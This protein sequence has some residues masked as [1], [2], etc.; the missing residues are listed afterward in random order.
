MKTGLFFDLRN[1]PEWRRPWPAVYADA[2]GLMADLDAYVDAIWLS[3]HHD[4]P[5][6][7]LPQ[8]L[9]MAAAVAARTSHARIGTAVLLGA[10]RHPR[11][12]AEQAAVVDLV[13]DGRTELGIGAGSGLREF[14][15]FGV[16]ARER[17]RL[18]NA[19]A[20]AV[21]DLLWQPRT[22]PPPVQRRLPLWLGYQG[23]KRAAQAGDIG[24][25]LLSFSR[26]AAEPYL[27]AHA[28]AGHDPG[29]ARM[30]GVVNV[31]VANDP[32]RAWR[33]I[34]HNAAYQADTYR[35]ATALQPESLSPVDPEKL[36]TSRGGA[37]PFLQTLTVDDTVRYVTELTKDLPVEHVYFWASIAGM[38]PD[39]AAE[40]LRLLTDEV[41][42]R[43]A[44]V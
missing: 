34:R 6:G 38:S 2:L 25:G 26:E 4:F 17:Y 19:T 12:I 32:E 40:H 18:T 44:A 39:V 43:L 24:A 20:I 3:E 28:A 15:L 1:P 41:R 31:V 9:T 7:Y 30:G 27:V 5:D 37:Q 21:R 8:P 22:T 23:P 35:A 29:T 42:P 36:R 14:E 33:E 16:D 11:H 10:V 13:S